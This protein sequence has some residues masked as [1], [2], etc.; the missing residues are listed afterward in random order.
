MIGFTTGI[1]LSA[2]SDSPVST[3]SLKSFTK[4][5]SLL[6]AS[7]LIRS[8]S[9]IPLSVSSSR[10]VFIALSLPQRSHLRISFMVNMM[11]TR[12]SLAIHPLLLDRSIR[13]SRKAYN[14]IA[15]NERSA[16]L[17]SSNNAI[18]TRRN[19]YFSDLFPKKGRN[20]PFIGH[21]LMTA[22]P[23]V[24]QT[25]DYFFYLFVCILR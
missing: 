11:N 14:T 9:P 17:G 18:G 2:P 15:S 21:L 24:K 12:L 13:L 23:V 16:N 6:P 1:V 10:M 20:I 19:L 8:T 5:M 22:L 4:M 3:Y 25:E 7:L